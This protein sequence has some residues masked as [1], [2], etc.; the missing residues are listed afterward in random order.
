M[1]KTSQKKIRLNPQRKNKVAAEIYELVYISNAS[2][3][4]KVYSN[5]ILW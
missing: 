2:K 5:N 3:Y 1:I 4:I